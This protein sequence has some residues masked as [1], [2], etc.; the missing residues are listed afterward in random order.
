LGEL[1]LIC[2]HLRKSD[3]TCA[4]S[5][6]QSPNIAITQSGRHAHKH[7]FNEQQ[8][9]I[10]SITTVSNNNRQVDPG[11]NSNMSSHML[12]R[13][14]ERLQ[15]QPKTAKRPKQILRF[16]PACA[17]PERCHATFTCHRLHTG[18]RQNC[19]DTHTQTHPHTPDF[20]PQSKGL[21]RS[22]LIFANTLV[23]C[24]NL[25]RLNHFCPGILPAA[26]TERRAFEAQTQRLV[27]WLA[28][29]VTG[30]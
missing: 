15:A 7:G 18:H 21:V 29:W 26:A 23:T 25:R 22:C 8:T 16:E 5:L 10:T 11:R 30:Y 1:C 20:T 13:E 6:S 4:C 12:A 14:R 19:H 24:N 2:D 3:R 9:D 28:V 27:S 17:S